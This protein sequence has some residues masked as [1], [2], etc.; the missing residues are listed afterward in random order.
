MFH[1]Q[2]NPELLIILHD[3]HPVLLL[4]VLLQLENDLRQAVQRQ[5]KS[6]GREL[7]NQLLGPYGITATTLLWLLPPVIYG[8][9]LGQAARKL[10]GEPLENRP[11]ACYIVCILAALVRS[12]G[13]TAVIWADSVIYGY[14]T[15]A[16]VFGA[17]AIRFLTGMAAAVLVATVVMPL[18]RLLR[19]RNPAE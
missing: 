15:F 8:L 13:N 14:Y 4:P 6:R 11:A 19:R 12:A 16:L 2:Q 1:Q 17:V 3:K 10:P 18:V 9:I 7:L 5:E